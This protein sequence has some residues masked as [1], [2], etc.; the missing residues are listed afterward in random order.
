M[1]IE[2]N[3][4]PPEFS[5]KA[6]RLI[7]DL[8]FREDDQLK[9]VDGIF[10]YA[11]T[12]SIEKLVKLL[13]NILS[14]GLS[15]KIFITGGTTPKHLAEELGIKP[16]LK[17][18][19]LLLNAFELDKYRNLEVYVERNST[20]TL[21]NVTETLKF[22]EFRD[23]GSLLFIFKSH[24]AGRGYLTLRKY[25]PDAE[26]LQKTFNAKYEIAEKEITRDNWFTFDFGRRRVWGEYLRIKTYGRRGDIEFDEVRNLVEEIEENL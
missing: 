6:V 26:I 7:T 9:K 24:P 23:C 12:V 13:D 14:R 3:P 1:E 19:D 25:F 11:S 15:N 10:V 17:E 21:E 4:Q 22:S 18:A 20:N 16:H 5:K 8:C 2:R